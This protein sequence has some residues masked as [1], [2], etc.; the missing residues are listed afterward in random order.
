VLVSRSRAA[1]HKRANNNPNHGQYMTAQSTK[2]EGK[3]K[4]TQSLKTRRKRARLTEGQID[5]IV[6]TAKT[7]PALTHKAIADL[8]HVERSTVSKILEKYN[9]QTGD[10]DQYERQRA[11]IFRGLQHKFLSSITD[12]DIAKTPAVQRVTSAAILY[13]KE[14]LE[15][16]KSTGNIAVLIDQ[17]RQIK[18]SET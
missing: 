6:D 11:T 18:A 16:G 4:V 1:R 14:R 7:C 12:D 3:R 17:I 10:A 9:I 5:K 2:T 8:N 13:D 15:Q